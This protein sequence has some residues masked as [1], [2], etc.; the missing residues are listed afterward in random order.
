MY[1][2]LVRFKYVILVCLKYVILA[3]FKWIKKTVT[4]ASEENGH[5]NAVEVMLEPGDVHVPGVMTS[6]SL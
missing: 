1:V 2:I 4:L 5:I 6:R 3:R